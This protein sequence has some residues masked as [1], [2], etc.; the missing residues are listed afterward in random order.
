MLL[1]Y[2]HSFDGAYHSPNQNLCK[3]PRHQV[4]VK[5]QNSIPQKIFGWRENK[6]DNSAIGAELTSHRSN[7]PLRWKVIRTRNCLFDQNFDRKKFIISYSFS[8]MDIS[9]L[10]SEVNIDFK[11]QNSFGQ[12]NVSNWW[13]D[14]TKIEIFWI[15]II[16]SKHI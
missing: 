9:N 16:A 2:M 15:C 5:F 7:W 11:G 3:S 8:A 6:A 14:L 4:N 13:K 12:E 10:A 1:L